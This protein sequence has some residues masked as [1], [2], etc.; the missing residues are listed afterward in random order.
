MR[1]IQLK[2]EDATIEVNAFFDKN[3]HFV[4]KYS[5]PSSTGERYDTIESA[6][7]FYPENRPQKN[8]MNDYDKL[9]SIYNEH[10]NDL[11]EYIYFADDEEVFDLKN[12]YNE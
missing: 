6:A 10:E 7:Y 3:N 11:D 2:Y 5:N 1:N 9:V 12:M 8:I 4:I